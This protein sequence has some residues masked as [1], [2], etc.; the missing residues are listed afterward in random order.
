MS[1]FKERRNEPTIAESLANIS[2]HY[3]N[4]DEKVSDIKKDMIIIKNTI[5]GNG[6]KG[7]V[8]RIAVLENTIC[9]KDKN[10]DKHKLF[11]RWIVVLAFGIPSVISSILLIIKGLKTNV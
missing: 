5:Y 9:E 7:L 6:K 10:E 8:E 1:N 11:L 4:L 3:E 2:N